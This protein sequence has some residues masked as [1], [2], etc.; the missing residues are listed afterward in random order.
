M[1]KKI[2]RDVKRKVEALR[3]KYAE[4]YVSDFYM[5]TGIPQIEAERVE[6][7]KIDISKIMKENE[8]NT[9][10][11]IANAKRKLKRRRTKIEDNI[12]FY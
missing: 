1:A 11:A 6:Q 5:Q 12:I 7:S 10:K 9:K 3:R 4:G 2:P 8:K